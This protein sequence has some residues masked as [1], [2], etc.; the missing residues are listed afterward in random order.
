MISLFNNIIGP[1]EKVREGLR[2]DLETLQVMLNNWRAQ[3]FGDGNLLK[4]TTIGGDATPATRYVAN[5]GA[6]NAPTWDTVNLANGVQGDLPFSHLTPASTAAR[7]LGRRSTSAG[8]FEEISLGP[9]LSMTGTVLSGTG[10]T[11]TQVNTDADYT[12]GGPFTTTGT[13]T[14]ATRAKAAV[15]ITLDQFCGSFGGF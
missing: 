2:Q 15:D 12:S 1:W 14:L 8:D 9:G 13:V 6:G 3:T 10:G 11:V 7:L 5:T 4:A